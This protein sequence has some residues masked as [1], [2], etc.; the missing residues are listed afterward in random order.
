M[1]QAARKAGVSNILLLTPPPVHN[2]GRIRHQQQVWWCQ[3]VA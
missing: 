3:Q 2:D 1:V